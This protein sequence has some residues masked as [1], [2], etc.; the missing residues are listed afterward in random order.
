MYDMHRIIGIRFPK[1]ASIGAALISRYIRDC[2]GLLNRV[3]CTGEEK[4]TY[5]Q[6]RFRLRVSRQLHEPSCNLLTY[7]SKRFLLGL[8]M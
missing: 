2:R 4:I 1:I 7:S 8:R 6:D 3:T 5:E